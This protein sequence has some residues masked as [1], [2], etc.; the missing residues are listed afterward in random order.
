MT[1]ASIMVV[2]GVQDNVFFQHADNRVTW[3]DF[4]IDRAHFVMQCVLRQSWGLQYQLSG[5]D[6]TFFFIQ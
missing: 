5:C 3:T 6:A 1:S 2:F 4:V